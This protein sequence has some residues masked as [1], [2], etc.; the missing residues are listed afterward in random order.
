MEIL[1]ELKDIKTKVKAYI[2]STCV[3]RYKNKGDFDVEYMLA[4]TSLNR[5]IKIH[6]ITETKNAIFTSYFKSF[7]II[8]KLLDPNKCAVIVTF[9]SDSA[10]VGM[11]V[12]LIMLRTA[13]KIA[14]SIVDVTTP[15]FQ[16]QQA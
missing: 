12:N 5:K 3:I 15:H 11:I 2:G 7:F 1:I 9:V 10:V 13:T 8:S 16:M 4:K 14:R 6:I